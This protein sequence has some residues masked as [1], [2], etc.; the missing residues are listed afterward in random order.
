MS[1]NQTEAARDKPRTEFRIE[2]VKR[3]NAVGQNHGRRSDLAFES[4]EI[5]RQ[6]EALHDK[7]DRLSGVKPGGTGP[8][9]DEHVKVE[10]A[11]MVK[12]IG[13]TKTALA[14][15]RH[16]LADKDQDRIH[17]ATSELDAIVEATE[18][19]TNRILMASE[20][21]TMLT[22]KIRNDET[23]DEQHREALD[24]I[25]AHSIA[26]LEACNFQDITGQ[27]ITKVVSAMKFIEDRI[28]G[29][30]EIW[31]V[32]A[33]AE[34]PIPAEEKLEGD[35]ALLEGPQLENQGLDQSDV[36]ALFD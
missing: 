15:L 10:I 26:I 6:I 29:M 20:E 3:A 22:D 12:E 33:F 17:S 25:E 36:D 21:I 16:P 1:V 23:L 30:I 34:L 35:A 28:R 9:E 24:R 13:R 2:R 4:D 11:R 19:A 8:Q 27:R 7:I 31:G 18:S 5:L 14:A 32:D